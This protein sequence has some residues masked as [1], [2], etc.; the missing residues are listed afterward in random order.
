MARKSLLASQGLED[1]HAPLPT[2]HISQAQPVPIEGLEPSS[3]ANRPDWVSQRIES[4]LVDTTLEAMSCL[5][6]HT[7]AKLINYPCRLRADQIAALNHLK[8]TLGVLPADLIRDFVDLGLRHIKEEGV[9][10][11]RPG[12]LVDTLR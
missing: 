8:N 1:L 5:T 7:K 12:T 3:R 6:R 9:P 4:G 10:S 11:V 2:S